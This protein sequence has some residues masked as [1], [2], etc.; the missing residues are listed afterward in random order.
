MHDFDLVIFYFQTVFSLSNLWTAVIIAYIPLRSGKR[1]RR[2]LQESRAQVRR[3][4][5]WR[6]P[7]GQDGAQCA[8]SD[9]K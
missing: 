7:R 5:R 4:N 2:V 1:P 8:E 3:H 9:Q 6:G